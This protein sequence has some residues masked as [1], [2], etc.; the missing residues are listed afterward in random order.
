MDEQLYQLIAQVCQYPWKSPKRQKAMNLLLREIQ[1]L[2]G[3]GKSPHP[4]YLDALNNTFEWVNRQICQDFNPARPLVQ[5]RLLQWINSYLY[6]R[7]KDLYLQGKSDRTYS[8]DAPIADNQ[9]E[10]SLLELL[11]TTGFEI[12]TRS[13]LDSYIEQIE[14]EQQQ[15]IGLKLEQY[16][17]EDPQEKLRNCRPQSYPNCNCQLLSS[18]V[19]L[20]S[21]PDK[22]TVLAKELSINY[23]TLSAS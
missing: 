17:R 23:Q 4:D 21:A 19:L 15:I 14:R 6:W 2:P 1:L 5:K 3:L 16:V 12:P 11:P 20:K 22:F 9:T 7:I 13:G 10:T 8:L 18:R